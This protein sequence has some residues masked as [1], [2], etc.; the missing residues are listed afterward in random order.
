MLPRDQM[1]SR[2]SP[3]CWCGNTNLQPFS[4]DYLHCPV[5]ET[6]V[7]AHMPQPEAL[8]VADDERD[9]Y[10]KQYYETLVSHFG[11]PPLEQRARE[12]LAER[13]LYWLRALLKY[14][15]PPANILELG[16]AHGGFVALTRAAGFQSTGLELSPWLVEFARKAFDI[17]VLEGPVESQQ[18]A[19]ASLDVVALMDVI[20]HLN[21]PLQTI[22][23]CLQLLKPDGLFL[24]QTPHYHE[25]KTFEQMTAEGDRFLEQLKPDQHL[26]L[27]SKSSIQLLFQQAGAC[28]VIFE[29]AIFAHY[30]MFLV[31]GRAPIFTFPATEIDHCLQ[32]LPAARLTLALLDLDRQLHQLEGRYRESETDRTARLNNINRLQA[33]LSENQTART[34]DL[35]RLHQLEILLAQSQAELAARAGTIEAQQRHM[36]ELEQ[37]RQSHAANIER[38]LQRLTNLEIDRNTL[39]NRINE[40]EA[41]LAAAA[42]ERDALQRNYDALVHRHSVKD[43]ELMHSRAKE[44]GVEQRIRELEEDLAHA[45]VE[46][47][48]ARKREAEIEARR[49]ALELRV[50]ESASLL[51]QRQFSIER[52]EVLL[53]RIRHSYIFHVMRKLGLWG[54]LDNSPAAPRPKIPQ[55]AAPRKLRRVVID[56]TPVLPGGD[57]GGAKPLA[58]GLIRQMSRQAPECEFILLTKSR[59]HDELGALD[60]KNVHRVCVD[61]PETELP[62]SEKLAARS[63]KWLS[64][65][66]PA[67]A[68]RKT[69]AAY[70]GL[71][72]SSSHSLLK[73]L[74]ADLLFCPFTAPYF[75]DPSVPVVSVILDLQ[76]AYYPQ[77][78]ESAQRYE[79][80]KTFRQACR[81]SSRIVCISDHV[82]TTV[83][84]NASISPDRVTTIHVTLPERL[85]QATETARRRVLST[86]QLQPGRFLL[87]PANFWRHKNHEV[88]L[89]AFGIYRAAYPHSDLRLVLTGAPG[90]RRDELMDITCRMKLDDAVLFPGFLPD[91]DLAALLAECLAVVFPSLFEG[92][93]MPV[94]EAM[95]AGAPVLC[96]NLTSLPEVAGDA[97]LL[98]DPRKP[99]DIASAID[100]IAQDAGLRRSLVEKGRRR[101]QWFGSGKEMASRYLAVFREALSYGVAL[102][103]SIYGVHED[104][105]AGERLAIVY[106]SGEEP[107]TLRVTVAVPALVP[108][109][110]VTVRIVPASA[111][112]SG[113]HQIQRGE[114]VTIEHRLPGAAGTVELLCSPSFQPSA[115]GGGDDTRHLVCQ[116]P[117]VEIAGP[118]GQTASLKAHAHV[119]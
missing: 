107:R 96:G 38:L 18:I 63:H 25:G 102:E 39:A 95:A 70:R 112:E 36:V 78:F 83:L 114:T 56:L 53:G 97:A 88:L 3:S 58:L 52:Q 19:P 24:L 85:R 94:L 77:F 28:R 41:R 5:C 46:A 110:A 43:A 80:D 64:K 118:G 109:E 73:Q 54:W 81:V 119:M 74:G 42:G 106:G 12:D 7:L 104:G 65:V 116:L 57:N 55:T 66:L 59:S 45:Q 4:A 44:T 93:G 32:N 30:D 15:L 8:L 50:H 62:A 79:R 72:G 10:G 115:I 92:F 105:W 89:T 35:E 26:Y 103:P 29:P 98:F 82:R 99:A 61:Q 9:L 48:E 47:G 27:F 51:Q 91:E 68:L 90:P 84:Q 67:N 6:L 11:Y 111:E 13:C 100:R 87:Y 20:E 23:H 75:F 1:L 86:L 22:Q 34:A 21:D 16:C 37:S 113:V 14:K 69:A 101:V 108:A 33:L 71:S 49:S 31:A 40:V 2:E 17:P 76:Y 60:A 117:A